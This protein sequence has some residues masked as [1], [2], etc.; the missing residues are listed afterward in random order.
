MIAG[1]GAPSTPVQRVV[2][3]HMHSTAS[4]GSRA[5]EDVAAAAHAAGISAI[6]LTDHDTVA[7]VAAARAAGERLGLRVITGVELSAEDNGRE[8][9]VLGLHLERLDAIE[10]AME[11][12]RQ[13]RIDRAREMVA[14]LNALGVPVTF[15]AV[16]AE[17]GGGAVGRPHVA[18][19]VVAGGWVGDQRDVFDRYIG[20]GKPANVPKAKLEFPDAIALIHSAGGLAIVAHPGVDFNRP[21][22]ER[23]VGYGLDGLEVL[24]PSNSPDEQRRLRALTEHFGLV[25][26]GGSDWHGADQGPRTI[27]MMK[28]PVAVLEKQEARLAARRA[29]AASKGA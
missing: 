21:R 24:H 14:K 6:A 13:T 2:D 10:T 1:T 26:S 27:G 7:G 29:G 19:A 5:P 20:H 23:A 25:P 22:V 15:D 3:L 28:V 18:R 12:F 16:I 8:V 4:D 17:A 11:G 9:H